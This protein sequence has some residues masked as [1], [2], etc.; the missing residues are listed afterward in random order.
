MRGGV[1]FIGYLER[2]SYLGLD[3]EGTLVELGI[4]KEL[5]VAAYE[6][7][8][9]ELVISATFEFQ[10]FHR[11][12]DLSIAQSLFTHLNPADIRLCLSNLRELVAADHRL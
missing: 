3:K 2:G 6:E 5:G 4:A 9:P 8:R 10:K 7:K 11:R 1:H 12:P